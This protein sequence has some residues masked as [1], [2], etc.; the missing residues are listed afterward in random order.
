MESTF[1]FRTFDEPIWIY[2]L[3]KTER[4]SFL[5]LCKRYLCGAESFNWIIDAKNEPKYESFG[6]RF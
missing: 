2:F 4:K 6:K 3:G 5:C 1:F